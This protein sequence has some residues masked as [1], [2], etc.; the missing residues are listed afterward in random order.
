MTRASSTRPK[1]S[2]SSARL[3]SS[4]ARR[5]RHVVSQVSREITP[6]HRHG[7]G[8]AHRQLSIIL[9]RAVI[10]R[11]G[12]RRIKTK[13][14]AKIHGAQVLVARDQWKRNARIKSLCNRRGS[15]GRIVR[16]AL[17]AIDPVSFARA[18]GRSRGVL[19][20]FAL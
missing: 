20:P 1:R 6:E 18:N 19:A 17:D 2:A 14:T 3:R 12:L 15:P 8:E 11:L 9:D 10:E 5:G 13:S 4:A 7:M 16:I